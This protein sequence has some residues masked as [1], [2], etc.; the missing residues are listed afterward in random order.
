MR[1]IK[2]KYPKVG[3]DKYGHNP[4]FQGYGGLYTN[5]HVADV[6]N[7]NE[8]RVETHVSSDKQL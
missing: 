7:T 1:I 8:E 4:M 6:D 5:N 3:S 2:A